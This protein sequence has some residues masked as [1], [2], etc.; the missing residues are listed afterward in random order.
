MSVVI[1]RDTVARWR[2]KQVGR[3]E[4]IGRGYI[5]TPNRDGGHGLEHS[6]TLALMREKLRDRFLKQEK[7][8][9]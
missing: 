6:S 3:V 5:F 9:T 4:Y 8:P 1:G 7:Q 2:G